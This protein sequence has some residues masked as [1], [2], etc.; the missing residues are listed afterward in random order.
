MNNAQ[1]ATRQSNPV[2]A[3]KAMTRDPNMVGRFR[4]VMGDKAPQFMASIVSA[5][6]SNKELQKAEPSS[7]MAAG[8]IAAT[9][10]L[11]VNQSLGF[12]AIVPYK[13]YKSG[14][15]AAQLQIMTKGYVQ[16]ALRSGQYLRVNAGAVYADEYEGQDL[17]SGELRIHNVEGGLRASD[18]F[19]DT[20]EDV[21]KAGIVGYF[22]YVKLLNGF[23]RTEFWSL[24]KIVNHGKRYSKSFSYKGA[25][26]Q[27]SFR[28]MA[29]KTVLKNTLSS[30]GILSTQ[31]Q[32][33]ITR[34]Q[35][36]TDLQGNDQYID[37]PDDI[38]DSP[39]NVE[40]TPEIDA[41]PKVEEEPDYAGDG[42]FS[43][44]EQAELDAMWDR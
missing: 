28:A 21:K 5:V 14:E 42:G 18:T 29:R 2:A 33:A 30:W 16:L 9:L 11:D 23:E 3:I 34:D 15:V 39:Q 20:L 7:I 13:N 10:D 38:V 12:S 17:V 31:M 44:E 4:E 26:W 36:S 35:V 19:G 22:A 41:K 25:P 27:A 40:K 32:A 1:I 24:E 6:S 43:E 37:N 8:M